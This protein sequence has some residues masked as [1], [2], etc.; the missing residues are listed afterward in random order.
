MRRRLI[1][2][3]LVRTLLAI[4]AG[5]PISG[6]KCRDLE[7]AYRVNLSSTEFPEQG[8]MELIWGAVNR[9]LGMRA[10]LLRVALRP[11][12]ELRDGRE[13]LEFYAGGPTDLRIQGFSRP[14]VTYGENCPHDILEYSIADLD[15]GAYTVV[16]RRSSA[17]E[18][19]TILNLSAVWST[20]DGED[21]LIATVLLDI[22]E[23]P[24]DAGVDDA[25]P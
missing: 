13:M 21:A 25:G 14:S 15:P 10:D 24:T 18:G 19:H 20:F 7:P 6:C 2:T 23:L 3:H 1:Q 11:G 16:H 9:G 4:V 22:D 12:T 8:G 17:P 5:L